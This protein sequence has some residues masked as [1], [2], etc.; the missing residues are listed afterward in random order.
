M[1]TYV[2]F[3]CTRAIYR[4]VKLKS[5]FKGVRCV[6]RVSPRRMSRALESLLRLAPR[7]RIYARRRTIQNPCRFFP[8]VITAHCYIALQPSRRI[9]AVNL[10]QRLLGDFGTRLCVHCCRSFTRRVAFRPLQIVVSTRRLWYACN[11]PVLPY[12]PAI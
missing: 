9:Y 7:L 11:T 5:G 2:Q 1:R 6:P 4:I 3:R 10:L 12:I 8:P